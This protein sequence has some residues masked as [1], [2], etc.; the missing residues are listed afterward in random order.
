MASNRSNGD[1][2]G[3]TA[4]PG[5]GANA[6]PIECGREITGRVAQEQQLRDPVRALSTFMWDASDTRALGGLGTIKA[7]SSSHL[8]TDRV[9][10]KSFKYVV[11]IAMSNTNVWPRPI[12]LR[13]PRVYL[14]CC[15]ARPDARV[16]HLQAPPPL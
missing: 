7:G 11:E 4:A 2:C 5:D 9:A 13:A 3:N 1:S 10:D 14:R 8:R 16:D 6:V 15:D 12:A